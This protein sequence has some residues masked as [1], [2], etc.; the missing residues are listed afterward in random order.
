M[1]TEAKY[2]EVRR[3]LANEIAAGQYEVGGKFPTDLELCERFHCSR[4][5]VREA[6]R[7][8]QDH[9]LLERRRGFGTVVASRSSK[10]TFTM[11]FSSLDTLL[12]H[13]SDSYFEIRHFGKAKAHKPLAEIIGC[14]VGE[15][16][17]RI[18]G[19][20][21]HTESNDSL[22]CAVIFV[23][24][25]Y[26]GLRQ[27]L[28]KNPP[29]IFQL[30]QEKYGVVVHTVDQEI[31]AVSIDALSAEELNVEP[32]SPGLSVVRHYYD[33]SGNLFQVAAS[34]YGGSLFS[35]K[36]QLVRNSPFPSKGQ[37][38]KDGPIGE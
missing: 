5:T 4:H 23:P 12:D 21:R 33:E 11:E 19:V 15:T 14:E 17:L 9:G 27:Y 29:T 24:E 1:V 3:T 31:S 37:Q 26:F 6:V 20:R 34:I 28:H 18:A 22:S 32:D 35:I 8:L 16:W 30:L 13:A 10:T 36:S 25:P 38:T 7:E 2:R